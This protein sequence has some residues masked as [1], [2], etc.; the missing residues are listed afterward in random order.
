MHKKM[1]KEPT[2]AHI[3]RSLWMGGGAQRSVYSLVTFLTS[4]KHKIICVS[5]KPKTMLNAQDLGVTEIVYCALPMTKDILLPSYRLRKWIANMLQL[6]FSIRLTRLLKEIKVDLVHS[7][8]NHRIDLQSTIVLEKVELP[9]IWTIRALPP[10]NEKE[11]IKWKKACDLII[12]N[13]FGR[14][15]A[16]SKA[17][18]NKL[19]ELKICEEKDITVI[20]NGIDLRYFSPIFSNKGF[21][22]SKLKIPQDA[23]L[24]GAVGRLNPEKGH[25][26]FIEAAALLLQKVKNVFFA[27][28]GSGPMVDELRE[29]IKYFGLEH[30]FH[31]VGYLPDVRPFLNDLDVFVFPSRKEGFGLALLEALASGLPCIATQVGGIPEI[32]GEDGGLMVPP[33]SPEALAEAMY[34]MLSPERR[35]EYAMRSRTIAE[36]FSIDACVHKYATIY[37]ELLSSKRR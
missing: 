36:R 5:P 32:L 2:I 8:I 3:V 19:V 4:Y 15:V 34:E 21:L 12:H 10:D 27:I 30:Y 1:S 28:A 37:E 22:R 33:E 25:D 9:M 6:T 18:V 23:V 13:S 7:H 24:F 14:I 20:Y 29:K 35:N 31:L 11:L 26:I 17:I 16:V